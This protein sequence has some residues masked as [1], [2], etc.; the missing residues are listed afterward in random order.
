[1]DYDKYASKLL[2]NMAVSATSIAILSYSIINAVV[3]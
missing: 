3:T 2:L 1:M